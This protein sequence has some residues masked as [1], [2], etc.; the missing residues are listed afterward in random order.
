MAGLAVESP[1]Y[2]SP[3]CQIYSVGSLQNGSQTSLLSK[4]WHEAPPQS[5]QTESTIS[6]QES[7][8]AELIEHG[9]AQGILG[10]G[11]RIAEGAQPAYEALSGQSS[12]ERYPPQSRINNDQ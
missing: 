9:A 3:A 5:P 8:V 6:S 1:P 12:Y 4:D 10:L 2:L 11:T 7:S